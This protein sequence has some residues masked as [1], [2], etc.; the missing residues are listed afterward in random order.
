[1][2]KIR[3][4]FLDLQRLRGMRFGFRLGWRSDLTVYRPKVGIMT[5][6]KWEPAVR[7]L[8]LSTDA[9]R[10]PRDRERDDDD[11]PE[12]PLDEPLPEPIQDPPPD[13]GPQGP[14]VVQ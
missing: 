11:T 8:M 13:P 14:Y 12:T 6:H 10:D 4:F 7:R 9:E 3:P 5:P 1:V 2:A